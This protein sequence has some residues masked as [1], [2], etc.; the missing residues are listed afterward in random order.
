M[1]DS[2]VYEALDLKQ[3]SIR[4]LTILSTST[5]TAIRRVPLRRGHVCLSYTWGD[6]ADHRYIEVNGKGLRVRPNLYAFLLR[7]RKDFKSKELWIDAVCIDQKNVKEKNAQVQ[8]MVEIYRSAKEVL[9]WAGNVGSRLRWVTGC[10]GVLPWSWMSEKL[11]NAFP[12]DWLLPEGLDDNPYFG[13][14][15]IVQEIT[16]GKRVSLLLE[17]G[18]V[19]FA[20]WRE[21]MSSV[22]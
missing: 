3:K 6:D 13:R 8:M 16:L 9:I 14:T 5:K 4:V 19:P 11:A 21:C 12:E 22:Q 2:L 1:S 10:H 7:R 17:S 20:R 18:T 15:W